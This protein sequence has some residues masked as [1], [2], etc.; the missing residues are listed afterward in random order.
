MTNTEAYE[1]DLNEIKDAIT[2]ILQAVPQ[3]KSKKEVALRKEVE[4]IASLAI[5]NLECMKND[6]IVQE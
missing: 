5:A 1:K 2:R 4:R 6:Y 3:G